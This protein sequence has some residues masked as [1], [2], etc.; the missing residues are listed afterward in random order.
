MTKENYSCK[1]I[2]VNMMMTIEDNHILVIND[3]ESLCRSIELI[4]SKHGYK[5]STANSGKSALEIIDQTDISIAL[6]DLKLPD[7][8][9]SELLLQIREKNIDTDI[10]IMTGY[11]SVDSAVIGYEIGACAYL[12]KQLSMDMLISTIDILFEKRRF[13]RE[14]ILAEN[15][16]RQSEDLLSAFIETTP[17]GFAPLTKT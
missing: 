15:A 17:C 8:S 3:N 11:A 14:K 6:V 16:L 4:L 2:D 13:A 12:T 5:L 1:S 7:I 9:G 10:I